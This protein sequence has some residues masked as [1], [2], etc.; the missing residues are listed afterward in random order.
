MK[1]DIAGQLPD[2][3]FDLDQIERMVRLMFVQYMKDSNIL[4]R[5]EAIELLEKQD[6]VIPGWP[7]LPDDSEWLE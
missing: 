2:F 6:S 4:N 5:E 1:V 3:W 7:T